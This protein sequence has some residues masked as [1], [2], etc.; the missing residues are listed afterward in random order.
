L[1]FFGQANPRF[2]R[3]LLSAAPPALG[4]AGFEAHANDRKKFEPVGSTTGNQRDLRRKF[5]KVN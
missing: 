4:P 1:N 5:I 2:H 3:E